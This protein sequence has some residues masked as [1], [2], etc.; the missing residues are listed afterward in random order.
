MPRAQKSLAAKYV[1]HFFHG[2]FHADEGCSAYDAV[3]DDDLVNAVN[4][5]DRFDVP[6]VEAT[7]CK[8]V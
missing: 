8:H 7:A 4:L 3:T 1:N 2:A 6:V 5:S